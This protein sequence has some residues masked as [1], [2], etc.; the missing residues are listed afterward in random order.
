MAPRPAFR[1][2]S[3]TQ[4]S[5]LS[6]RCIGLRPRFSDVLAAGTESRRCWLAGQSSSNGGPT[7]SA[8][9]LGTCEFPLRVTLR[10]KEMFGLQG[11]QWRPWRKG[12]T[13][14][15]F[16]GALSSG[17]RSA[18]AGLLLLILLIPYGSGLLLLTRCATSSC[19]MPCCTRSKVCCCRRSDR[20][21]HRAGPSWIAS[22]S[23][24]GGCG[25]VATM[26]ATAAAG[27]AVARTAVRPMVPVSRLR[28]QAVSLR[29]SAETGF[30][31]F[32]RPPPSI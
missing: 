8:C 29:G 19:G 14:A 20:K 17:W 6:A 22:S 7:A 10:T 13:C 18:A 1:H 32:E 12:D 3:S 24:P 28:I 21:L 31:L 2:Q 16:L 30:A 15:S 25:Q 26:P 4:S 23:C 5:T 9:Q 11:W 27:L